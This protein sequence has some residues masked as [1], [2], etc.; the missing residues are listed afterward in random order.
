[1]T[2]S[3]YVCSICGEDLRLVNAHARAHALVVAR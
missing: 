1:M 2:D 3:Y